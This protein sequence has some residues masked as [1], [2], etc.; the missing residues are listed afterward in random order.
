MHH[1]LS[2][3]SNLLVLYVCILRGSQDHP[4]SNNPLKGLTEIRKAVAYAW[5]W[6]IA[7]RIQIEII[8]GK[9]HPGEYKAQLICP[10]SVLTHNST[11]FSQQ[12]CGIHAHWTITKQ[13]S[14][15][16]P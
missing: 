3:Y 10:L 4:L 1:R 16:M 2:F 7:A 11:C 13:G 15:L 8:K 6:F 14:S 12:Q 9:R 5:L